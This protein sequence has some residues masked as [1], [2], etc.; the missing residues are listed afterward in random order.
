MAR[1]CKEVWTTSGRTS[2]SCISRPASTAWAAP[3]SVRSASHQPVKR[4][5]LFHSLSPWRSSTRRCV[6]MASTL[7]RGAEGSGGQAQDRGSE[8]VDAVLRQH[9]AD[10]ESA[11]S[12]GGV[13]VS[14]GREEG[15]QLR[16]KIG[17]ASGRERVCQ[18]V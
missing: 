15:D 17:R 11:G 13:V 4:L 3:R 12:L 1:V 16:G 6:A 2:C 14:E 10:A 8:L 9:R 7:G 18:Y 5:S